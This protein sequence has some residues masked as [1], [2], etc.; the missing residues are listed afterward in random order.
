MQNYGREHVLRALEAIANGAEPEEP[1]MRPLLFASYQAAPG[2]TRG[3]L[4][5][6]CDAVMKSGVAEIQMYFLGAELLAHAQLER[7][8]RA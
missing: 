3:L 5:P 1:V 8:A 4:C 7:V 2:E 6:G